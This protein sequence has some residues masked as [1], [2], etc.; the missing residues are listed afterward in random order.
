MTNPIRAGIL[1]ATGYTGA[2]LLETLVRHPNV[3]L[4]FATTRQTDLAG[5]YVHREHPNLQGLT[6]LKFSVYDPSNPVLAEANQ[7]L[8]KQARDSDVTFI[9]VPSVPHFTLQKIS[10]AMGLSL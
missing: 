4:E 1:G 2:A 9:C 7:T 6:D 10:S 8:L 5:T 3:E